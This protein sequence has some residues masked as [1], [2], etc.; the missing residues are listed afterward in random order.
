MLI[1]D[2]AVREAAANLA[3][4]LSGAWVIDSQAPADGAA[5]LVSNDG[6]G[7][8]FRPV[9]GGTIVQL[10]ITGNATPPP[11][12]DAT[13]A[14]QSVYEA[15]AAL[16]LPQGQRY[17]KAANLVTED[18]EDPEDIIMRT[19]ECDL[20]PAFEYKPGYVGHRPWVDLFDK[21]L[22]AAAADVP[23]MEA[24]AEDDTKSPPTA[25]EPDVGGHPQPD[26]VQEAPEESAS[27]PAQES[28]PSPQKSSP[29]AS[30]KRSK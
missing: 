16:R 12:V 29:R 4:S 2:A 7:I 14:E 6:R 21:A 22:V 3:Q 8:S 15:Q 19:L 1:T 10:W 17:N 5:H 27:P 30:K 23:S 20:L 13:P 28:K 25:D 24:S 9:F 11:P 26:A 18:D